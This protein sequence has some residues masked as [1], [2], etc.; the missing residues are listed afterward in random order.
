[1][2]GAERRGAQ[3]RLEE[4]VDALEAAAAQRGELDDR[5]LEPDEDRG[6]EEAPL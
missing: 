1:M 3:E 2:R 5:V 6:R 4:R